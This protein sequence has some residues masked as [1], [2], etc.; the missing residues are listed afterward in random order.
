[1]GFIEWMHSNSKWKCKY[2]TLAVTCVELQAN[3]IELAEELKSAEADANDAHLSCVLYAKEID[4]ARG[5]IEDLTKE[6]DELR[7]IKIGIADDLYRARQEIKAIK[8]LAAEQKKELTAELNFI[9][10]KPQPGSGRFSAE[11]SAYYTRKGLEKAEEVNN[12]LAEENLKLKNELSEL[13]KKAFRL[14]R[15]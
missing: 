8:V 3:N 10:L 14:C 9:K 2:E 11:Y 15:R 4:E 5:Q 1:M 6:N 12:K 13:A 7:Q